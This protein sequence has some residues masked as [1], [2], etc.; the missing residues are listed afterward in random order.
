MK[1]WMKR[2]ALVVA[3]CFGLFQPGML[4]A[5]TDPT[6]WYATD[7]DDVVWTGAYSD[8]DFN[9]DGTTDG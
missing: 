1:N 9:G 4:L 8:Q 5:Y 6:T 7:V 2:V 3:I